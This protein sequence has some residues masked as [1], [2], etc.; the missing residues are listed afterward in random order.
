MFKQAFLIFGSVFTNPSFR[1]HTTFSLLKHESKGIVD[2]DLISI[3]S[4]SFPFFHYAGVYHGPQWLQLHCVVT[5]QY[6]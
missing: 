3:I 6:H 1:R 4:F 5:V 2:Y